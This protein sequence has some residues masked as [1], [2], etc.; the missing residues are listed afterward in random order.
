MNFETFL[1]KLL[2]F[3]RIFI[4]KDSGQVIFLDNMKINILKNSLLNIRE[5]S[6]VKE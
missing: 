6:K 2:N 5:I 3:R 1:V 4:I